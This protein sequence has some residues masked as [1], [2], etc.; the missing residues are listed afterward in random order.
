MAAVL[1]S[2]LFSTDGRLMEQ[3]VGELLTARRLKIAIGESCTGGLIASRLTDVPG[4]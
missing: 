1:G 3:I 2:S 4:S